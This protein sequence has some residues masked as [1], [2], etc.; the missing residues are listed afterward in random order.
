MLADCL[1]LSHLHVYSLVMLAV[2]L[3][4][5]WICDLFLELK[6]TSKLSHYTQCKLTADVAGIKHQWFTIALKISGHSI[7]M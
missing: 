7:R 3:E 6:L 5:N 2:R 4:G 1:S